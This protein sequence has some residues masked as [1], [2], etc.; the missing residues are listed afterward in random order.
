MAPPIVLASGSPRRREL[1][2]SAGVPFE[3]RPSRVP[4]EQRAGEAPEAFARRV[5]AAKAGA[6][7]AGVGPEPARLVLG[8]D[9]IVVLGD[10][11]LGKPA[12]PADAVAILSRLAGRSH[13]VLTAVAVVDSGSGWE[14]EV[15]VETRVTMR[16]A[17]PE[18]LRAYVAT[19]EPL[20]KAGAY[21]VQGGGRRFVAKIEGSET[22]VIGLPVE[23]T[24]ALLREAGWRGDA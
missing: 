11:V 1:L 8:A 22:N 13:R 17:D 5:A 16:S 23:E 3:V 10:V 4:E 2:G 18:E 15:L 6:V 9:T 24:L 20:D 7:A 12:D 19:G 14:G 21:A